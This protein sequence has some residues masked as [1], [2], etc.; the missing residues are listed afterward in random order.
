[1]SQIH[2]IRLRGGWRKMEPGATSII[3][4]PL[5]SL[6]IARG[7]E[8]MSLA[9]AFQRPV[10]G[11]RK[12]IVNLCWQKASGLKMLSV[13]PDIRI[14]NALPEGRILLP[15]A[16]SRYVLTI[17]IDPAGVLNQFPWGEF[18]IEVAEAD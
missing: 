6:E 11:N 5:G 1:M 18:W 3:A 9:R 13:N 10:S 17:E 12:L 8:N 4:L 7:C 16:E 14:E 2:I 15:E